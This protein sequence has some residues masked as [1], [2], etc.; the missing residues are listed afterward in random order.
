M[1]RITVSESIRNNCQDELQLTKDTL[2]HY[3]PDR[4]PCQR[5]GRKIWSAGKVSSYRRSI[6]Y[7][8]DGKRVDGEFLC[9]VH[10]C[11]QCGKSDRRGGSAS[12]DYRHAIL[13]DGLVP[14]TY[15]TL[16]F[17]LT[18]L[19]DYA[20]RQHTVVQICDYWGISVSTLYRWKKRYIAH[21]E[22]WAEST[23][24]IRK[25]QAES[26]KP[27]PEEALTEAVGKSLVKVFLFLRKLPLDFFSRFAFSFLQPNHLT[28]FRPLVQKRRI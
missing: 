14:F 3:N 18:V 1:Q 8:K 27:S 12:G 23:E 25:L 21:Y 22:A 19:D 16:L 24:S 26:S 5:C 11:E 4:C 6:T 9:P 17:V 2:S 28:H 13:Q 15:F 7:V 10:L 20:K